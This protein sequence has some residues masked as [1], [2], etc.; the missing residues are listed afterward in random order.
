MAKIEIDKKSGYC[1]GVTRA[2]EKAEEELKKG[3]TLYC[4]GDIV[5]N[6]LEVERL[7]NLGLITI[8]LEEFKKLRNAR[9]LF[10]AHGE[11]PSTY[12]IAK[13]N[14]IK[15]IDASCPVVLALQ[16]RVKKKNQDSDN[17][18]QIAIYGRPGHAEVVGLMGQTNDKAIVIENKDDLDK[19]DFTK[20]INL[21]SQTTKRLDGFK[22]IA[23]LIESKMKE[24]AEF[25]S[26][27]TICRQVSNRVPNMK[28]FANKHDI[29]FF[30]AGKKSSNGKVLFSEC[31]KNNP[32]SHFISDPK[33]VDVSLVKENMS[34]GICGA[35]ST[36]KWQMEEV[37]KI[38][39]AAKSNLYLDDSEKF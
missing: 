5:H 22:E 32:N 9:V 4:L 17:N 31:K 29:I 39:Q 11:P 28:E 8:D 16:K 12:K 3:G 25:K 7:A 27:D 37:K 19:L 2:I 18:T 20:H 23:Q 30:V 1:F 24:G 13:Q 26:F 35:T 34:V 36:P 21:F 33:E 10:R 38:I 14:N 6:E 15:L